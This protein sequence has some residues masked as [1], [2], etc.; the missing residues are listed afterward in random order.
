MQ[1]IQTV[2]HCC[3]YCPK[4]R[5]LKAVFWTLPLSSRDTTRFVAQTRMTNVLTGSG[6]NKTCLRQAPKS[7]HCSRVPCK[8]QSALQAERKITCLGEETD[9]QWCHSITMAM[10]GQLLEL[11]CGMGCSIS[12]RV[13]T[14][15]QWPFL[16][17]PAHIPS[18]QQARACL[19]SFN[20][21]D[22]YRHTGEWDARHT[23]GWQ[24][25]IGVKW[26]MSLSTF[27]SKHCQR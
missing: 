5:S 27:P 11:G 8:Q 20:C 1:S 17:P 14:E 2:T 18:M 16:C 23:P 21:N 6:W 12:Y 22:E 7:P 24:L 15:H 4:W 10:A 3:I 19:S 9:Q 25:S 26:N 13:S